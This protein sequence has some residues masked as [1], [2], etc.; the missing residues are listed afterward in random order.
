[1][2]QPDLK[3]IRNIGIISHI[4]AGKTTVSERILYYCGEIHKLGEVHDGMATMD[5]MAQE[6]DRGITITA[7]ST[8]CRW[9]DTW[10]N[11]IDTP[12]H[13]DFT[14]E[15]ERSLRVL[16]GAV[17]IFSAV[18]G[19][20]PQSESVWHQ[21]DRY[22]VPRICLINKMDRVG[23]DYRAVME[24]MEERLGARTVLMQL[25]VGEEGNFSSVIDLL[26]GVELSFDEDELGAT[27]ETRPMADEFLDDYAVAREALIE[28]AADYDDELLS[29]FLEGIDIAAERITPA[30]R[31]GVL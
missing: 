12:G 20:Q 26:K 22:N 25:P 11:L 16:D 15:V 28:A 31:M 9:N 4:D 29:D 1:M 6:Q 19:V 2:S 18:E 8:T 23:A 10:I 27:V 14:I 30:L 7:T 24:Q 3:K 21:A 5:W 13:I 17:A